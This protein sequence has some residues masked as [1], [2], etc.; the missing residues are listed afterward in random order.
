VFRLTVVVPATDAPPTL[1]RCLAAVDRADDGPDEVIVIEGP[2]HL[3]AAAARNAGVAR[4]HGDVI[5]FVDSDVE[6]SRDVFTRI[7]AAFASAPDLTAVFGSY[8]DAPAAP[9]RISAFRNLLHH[10]VH[11]RGAGPAET[12]WTGLGAVR[13]SSFLAVG[14]FDHHRFPHPSVEDID[15][16]DRLS[17]RGDRIVLDPAIQGTHLKRWTLRSMLWTDLMRRG[18]PWV[19]LQVRNRRA[20]AALNCGWRCRASA[21]TCAAFVSAALL[22]HLALLGVTAGAFVLLNASFYRLLSRRR[23]AFD[24]VLGIGLHGLHYLVATV[25]VP[26]GIVVAV[27]TAS[28]PRPV[29]IVVTDEAHRV[30]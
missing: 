29:P 14:G 10:H 23:G 1:G 21:I 6:V 2:A 15:L 16:G 12:F 25:A 9:G 30:G 7:R 24:A 22:G 5:V 11:Q 27:A 13:R 26:L 8:D 19:A 28:R 17:R 3:S 18:V 4:A 20:S